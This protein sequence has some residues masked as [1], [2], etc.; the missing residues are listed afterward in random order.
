MIKYVKKKLLQ[1]QCPLQISSQTSIVSS[2]SRSRLHEKYKFTGSGFLL[3]HSDS[4]SSWSFHCACDF[5]WRKYINKQIKKFCGH[6][7]FKVATS[8][9]SVVRRG[10]A[11]FNKNTALIKVSLSLV[12]A[13]G[14]RSG[15]HLLAVSDSVFI[16]HSLRIN[17]SEWR[18]SLRESFAAHGEEG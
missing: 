16:V 6:L 8:Q 10:P 3:F 9:R 17:K 13:N 14:I 18:F 4:A 11:V 15:R 5:D 7:E 2:V 12:L 1:R